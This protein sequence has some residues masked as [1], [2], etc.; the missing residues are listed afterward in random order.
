MDQRT[1]CEYFRPSTVISAESVSWSR[2]AGLK[3]WGSGA[4]SVPGRATSGCWKDT[5]MTDT[6]LRVRSGTV[7][8]IK[9]LAWR[10]DLKSR[11]LKLEEWSIPNLPELVMMVANADKGGQRVAYNRDH[12]RTPRWPRVVIQRNLNI[13]AYCQ[14]VV[15]TLLRRCRRSPINISHYCSFTPLYS[16]KFFYQTPFESSTQNIL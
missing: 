16:F 4:S 2:R 6:G 13:S 3:S 10:I 15:K 9:A 5:G 11:W 8:M 7:V 14:C 12:E 1:F